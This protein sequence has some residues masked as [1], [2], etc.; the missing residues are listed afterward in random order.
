VAET[1][2]LLLQ[3]RCIED[4]MMARQVALAAKLSC[5]FLPLL[6]FGRVISPSSPV[7]RTDEL[8]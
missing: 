8:A 4:P 1:S 5:S 6:R 2:P 7:G 3:G